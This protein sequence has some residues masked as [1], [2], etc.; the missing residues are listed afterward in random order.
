MNQSTLLLIKPDSLQRGLA[1]KIIH[2]FE[3]KGLKIIGIKMIRL[4]EED[5]DHFYRH[6]KDKPF[7]PRLI[8]YM[9]SSPLIALVLSGPFAQQEARRIIGSTDPLEA[10]LGTIRGDWALM[11]GCNLVHASDSIETA[12]NEIAYFFD[13]NE[14]F[15]YRLDQILWLD[16]DEWE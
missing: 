2:K 4:D 15:D 1:G 3:S 14:L 7:F 5:V 12:E 10:S 13:K 9:T 6:H 11:K 16:E 8:N